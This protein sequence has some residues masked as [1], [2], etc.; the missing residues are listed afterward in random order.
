MFAFQKYPKVSRKV[1]I[2]SSQLDQRLMF[3][4]LC[5]NCMKCVSVCERLLKYTDTCVLLHDTVVELVW[6]GVWSLIYKKN[7]K[8]MPVG[9][10]N[11]GPHSPSTSSWAWSMQ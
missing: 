2:T 8:Q 1:T 7:F 11:P 3:L 4:D 10:T 9:I 5:G 6:G